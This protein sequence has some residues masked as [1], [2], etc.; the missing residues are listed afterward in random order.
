MDKK[1]A[2]IGG[3]GIANLFKTEGKILH[4]DTPFG[5]SQPIAIYSIQGKEILFTNR[6]ALPGTKNFEHVLPPHRINSRA[7]IYGLSKLGARRI[8]AIN[9]VGA[10]RKE[11]IIGNFAIVTQFIDMTKRREYSFFDGIYRGKNEILGD[12][13]R[14]VHVDMTNPF[15]SEINK[16]IV[17][18]AKELNY[19]IYTGVCY[20][21]TEGPR[22]ETPAEIKFYR[23]VGA[24]VVGMTLIPE[25]ILARE[26]GL[27]YTSL[28]LITNYAAGMQERVSLEEVKEVYK[29]NEE[30]IYNLIIRAI[31][32]L[33]ENRNCNC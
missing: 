11:L 18:S 8:I 26:I 29:K 6:H 19:E 30:R 2:I 20:V 9:S 3:S 33:G 16:V 24:D 25:V 10:L 17:E 23:N 22:L 7:L 13:S 31:S 15:C 4:V 21:C 28:S 5:I 12:S 1:I 32:K 27:C 14:V